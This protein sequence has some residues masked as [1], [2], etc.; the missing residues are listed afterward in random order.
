[1]AIE[2]SALFVTKDKETNEQM[3]IYPITTADNVMV[4]DTEQL[5]ETLE[6]LKKTAT[7]TA[8]G[9]MSA[10]DKSKL[11]GIASG[12]NKTVV[13]SA[14]SSTSTNPVQ[15]KVINTALAG[16]SDTSHTHTKSEI[17]LGN[18][19]NKSSA[20]IRGE[21]TKENVTTA[22][23]YT[24]PTTNTT[25]SDMTGASSSAA[26]KHGLV[27]APAAGAQAK[28]LRGDGTWQTPT[29]TKYNVATT[30]ANGLMSSTDKSKLD[31]IASGANKTTVDSSMSTTSTNPVQNKV[32]KAAI[33]AVSA[34]VD[35]I[36]KDAPE[37]YD[38][39]KE[40]SDYIAS[41]TTE[42]EALLAVAGNKVDKVDDM[43]L[44]HNDFTDALFTKL[45]GI[46]AGANKTT[47]DSTLSSTSTNPVQNKVINTALA[48]K[49]DTSHTH[50]KSEIGLGNVENKSSADIRG[51]LTKE[52]VT[53]ALG[54]TPPTTNT[55]YS[56]M[57][58]ASSSAAGKHGLVPAPAAGAQAKYLRGDGT[59]NTPTN[60]TY[61][62]MTAATAD[63]D[64]KAGLVPA[65]TKGN[66][67]KFLRGD[68]TW[69]TPTNTTYGVATTT[70][71]GLMSSSD[72]SKLD[73]IASGANKTTV[74]S[75]LSST[76]TNP[77]QNKVINTALAGKSDTSHTHTKD[78]IGLGNVENKSSETIRG[79]LTKENVT[80]ALGYTPPTTNTT[81]G[82]MTAATASAAGKAGLVPAPAAGAQGKYLRGDGTWNTPTNT[83][84]G[85]ATKS[86]SGLMSGSD[87][88]KLDDIESGA[89]KTVIDDALDAVSTNPVQNKAV[90]IALTGKSD[91]SHTHTKS[92]I[93]LGNVENKSSADIRGE[94]TKENV[95]TALGYT[96][97]TTNTTYSNMTGA[98]SSA[99]GKS[100]LVPAPTK[101]NQA[102]F[103]R[104]D[105]TWQTPT[106]TTYS[107][108]TAATADAAGK[109]GL[110]P[111]P[112]AGAQ[113]KYLRGDGTWNTPT[114]TTYGVATTS[115]NGLMS[116]SDKS[117]LDGIASGANKT[118]VDSAL[119][120]TS[121]NPVQNKVINTALAGKSDTSHTHTKSD[122]G[123]GNVENKSSATIRGELTKENV[124]TALGYTP[125]TTNTTYSDMTGATSSAT[126]THGLVPA[127]A[128]GAQAKYLRGDGTWNTPTN[129]TYSNMTAATASAA[130][131]AG[132][133]PAPGAGA[134]A[135]FLRGDGTW[136]TPANT[137]YSVATTSTNGLMSSSD[138]S[139]LDGIASGAN[140][141]TVDSAM[142]T[143]STNPVQ[144]KVV[145]AAID[146]VSAKV[147]NIIKDAP[148]AYDTLK[149]VSDY[150]ASH[151]TEYEA[152]LALA[153][154]KVDKV[155]GMGLSQ[156]DFTDTLLTKL[157]GIASGANK[158]T[159]D[160]ALNSTSTNPVQNKVINS[161]LAGKSDTDHTHTKSDIGLG[162]VE[163]KSSATIRG[164]L[165][166]ENVTT[167]LGYT[168]PTTNTTYSNMTAATTSA[169]GKAGL[170]PAPG[171]GSQ[172][173]FLR[174]DGTWATPTNTT[175][176]VA[177]TSTNGLMSSSDKSKL[178]GIASGANKTTVDSAL[179]STSTNPVQNKVINTALAGKSDTSHTHTKSDIGLGNVENKSSAD[180]RGELTK[181]NVTTALGYTPPT[182]NTTYSDM[183][184][185]TSSAA[186]THGL[187]P[188]PA[189]GA[190]GK[191]LR[192]DGTWQ[193]PTN[194]TYGVATTSANGLM[195][196][197]D[198]SKLDG[199]ASGANKTT[200]DSTLSS[201]STNPVQ[202]KVVNNALGGK[203]NRLT[204]IVGSDTASTNGWYKFA[205]QTMSGY[206]DSNLIFAV[207]STY[208]KYNTGIL[209]VQIRSDNTS[210][211]CPALGWL[212]RSG[213]AAGSVVAV[214]SGMTITL[215]VKQE[216]SQYGR[217]LFDVLSQ[218]SING[219]TSGI[220]L[221]NTTTKE[222]S[223]PAATV[224]SKD[225]G[226]ANYANSAGSAS[227]ATKATKDSSDQ[228]INS[229]YIKSISIS[230]RTVTITKGDNTTST[231]TTQDTNTTYSSMTAATS[232]AAGKAGLV[233]APAA[234]AQGKF[235][236]GDGTWQTPTNTTYGV[237]TNSANGLM[238]SSDKS[239]LDGIATGANKTTVDSTLSSTSTNPVQNKVINTAL[240]GKSD[241]SH[242]H[243]KD[244]IG[245]GNVENK[246]SETIR[247][248]L[249]K[250]NV[251][252]A[253]GYTPPT[254]NTT[255]SNM[256]AAT[257]SAAG[258]AGLVPA[259][260]AGAQAKFL[261][262]DGTWQT[263]TN[264]TY[265]VA[266]TS[267]N[268]L[269]SSA[270]KVKLDLFEAP[271]VL[272]ATAPTS[273]TVDTFVLEYVEE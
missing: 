62:N 226:T 7:K 228:T 202:N 141:T 159:V 46:A 88:S 82:N 36:I 188:A 154:N 136:Q 251:T 131:K 137:T 135:K 64:G 116:S 178:D 171:A 270:D 3:W 120:S 117:K 210:I 87:K 262:G 155:D 128:A 237:A 23:G 11:D 156:N 73:G 45:N 53:T 86:A 103:L 33:D 93:G 60:T 79:E 151:T 232:S 49:S 63:A 109:A 104:A 176:S 234:G 190:Q 211:Q 140:K 258:K 257:T 42:Y 97:P 187:V 218:S 222:T 99:D 185:A 102:K 106:N 249:T 217:I 198:K 197:S 170:V 180:I 16:K 193:T 149:E 50:T 269:M 245:L 6:G 165:T 10:S 85:N 152:L 18:V 2:K 229:T 215:Y 9:M 1:M 182:T 132:L 48:G 115:A 248:E 17:G 160:S 37:A 157:N 55:T 90:Y 266:T 184:A 143:T 167:A 122:I 44:S 263:P 256:T 254:T 114:N 267:A 243:T 108:M 22:L 52:N 30:T 144:N 201:S 61:S 29:D 68:G 71:N 100:G 147:D 200:V 56:D 92:E 31:G 12:A 95:T 118:T 111:A 175:Y 223:D 25:Y 32:V 13:D 272:A 231:Q 134:Q 203:T 91:T 125:P 101:G 43:G 129:T 239:K 216:V 96:P 66:Q 213:F 51:E 145:Q 84:Y 191:F 76:S 194:T 24:P 28:F 59:W 75:T 146:A 209:S 19:E 80:T 265:G 70:A 38:T 181:E 14:L 205:S 105:G 78:E 163:N 179:S 206:G 8:N 244:D 81:Y 54:Y 121:T 58:G 127:P 189:A 113:G 172:A 242:T 47:V 273:V 65:P 153:G 166:K 264:T 260:A 259:P 199:I 27:P 164:E 20:D 253:L 208:S 142:S 212:S 247:G 158:T 177:T 69:Q 138:K 225:L 35:N 40:V 240:A 98:T 220:T 236:R 271:L 110:V 168:P 173:K 252:T 77:V 162:N 174:G 241:T 67:G 192:G 124:T 5:D 195:S 57:T 83:T 26:G 4:G 107:N 250:A 221:H 21:L 204:A 230:G 74:D 207:T 139:K 41:H 161:A 214:I 235:L 268:G 133:V 148:E 233:P 246:S 261:R 112:G 227:S 183:K 39:L 89:T 123:L 224:T 94:L 186:G 238:S 150:I 169:A 126:G 196:S 255:Y 72:K 34:K 15:N 119:S 130:G 219:N